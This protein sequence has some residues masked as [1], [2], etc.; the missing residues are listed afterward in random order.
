M[1]VEIGVQKKP[2]YTGTRVLDGNNYSLTF[3]WNTYT[4]KWYLDIEGLNNTVSVN[5][6][7]LVCGKDLLDRYGFYELGQLWVIDNSGAN[8]DPTYDDFGSR[9][10]LEYTPRT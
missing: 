6:I 5:T 4:S 8:E 10:T 3:R 2:H 7:A 1:T 9:W